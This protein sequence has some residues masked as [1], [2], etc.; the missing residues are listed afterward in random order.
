M[1]PHT[2]CYQLSKCLQNLRFITASSNANSFF[3][4]YDIQIDFNDRQYQKVYLLRATIIII[5]NTIKPIKIQYI[6]EKFLNFVDFCKN[7]RQNKAHPLPLSKGT[8]FESFLYV[9]YYYSVS[10]TLGGIIP[11][12]RI[13]HPVFFFR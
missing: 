7:R 12:P 10:E 6:K 9:T 5:N 8:P 3:I 2:R 4:R 11:Y 1:T 13:P